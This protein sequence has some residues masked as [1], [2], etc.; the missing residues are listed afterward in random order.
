M[1]E[2]QLDQQLE[3]GGVEGPVERLEC[4]AS[5]LRAG[6]AGLREPLARPVRTFS[7]SA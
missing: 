1:V 3:V 2:P 6:V 7:D 4:R 5:A